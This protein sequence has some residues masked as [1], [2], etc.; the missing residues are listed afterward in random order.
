MGSAEG[1]VGEDEL[2]VPSDVLGGVEPV[3][4]AAVGEYPS[5]LAVGL[6]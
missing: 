5:E 6:P 3:G 1:R 2:E 4:G